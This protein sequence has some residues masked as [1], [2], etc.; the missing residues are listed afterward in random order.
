LIDRFTAAPATG[1]AVQNVEGLIRTA[2]FKPATALVG[3]LLQAAA[4]RIEAA[5]RPLPGESRKGLVELQVQ[6]L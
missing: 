2:I 3:F 4:Q 6:C 1:E 5:Y